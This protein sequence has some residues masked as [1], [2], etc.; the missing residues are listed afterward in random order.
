MTDIYQQILNK[1]NKRAGNQVAYNLLEPSP[2][3]TTEFISTGSGWLDRIIKRG[4]MGGIPIRK[5]VELA[6][7]ESTGKSY[8]A[9]QIAG[10][11]QKMSNPMMVVYFDS[12]SSLDAAFLTEAGC[13]ISKIIYVQAKSVEFVL[14]TIEDLLTDGERFLFVWDSLAMTPTESDLAGDYD[15]QSSMA[16]KARVL[17]KGLPKVTLPIANK[18]S[19]LLIINQLKTNISRNPMDMLVEPYFTPGGKALLYAYSLRIWLTRPKAKASF[20]TNER[21]ERIGNTV[22]ALI[23]KSRFGREGRQCIFKILW[24]GETVGICDEESWLDAILGSPALDSGGSWLTLDK[25][26]KFQRA[27]WMSKLQEPEFR[28][29]ILQI[30][31]EELI[32][33]VAMAPKDAEETIPEKPAKKKK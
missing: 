29:R 22:K 9:A 20:L 18:D 1:I 17:S 4:G 26:V 27:H 6:G 24:G 16:F 32:H 3:E 5:V 19:T 14:E 12:E 7:L 2:T 23:K 8:M 15:P 21:G 25:T 30:M 11:A 33:K 28:A 10:N 13:D 31:D